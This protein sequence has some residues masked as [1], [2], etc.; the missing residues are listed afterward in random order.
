MDA[1]LDFSRF[2]VMTFDCYGTLIDWE[3]GLLRG[4][5]PMLG[6]AADEID[7]DDLLAAYAQAEAEL[8]RGRWLPY[9]RV[10]AHAAR[11]VCAQL[12]VTPAE[13]E[14]AAFGASVAD[15]PA[16]P[17]SVDALRALGARYRL[18]VITNCDDDLFAASDERL[19]RPF[20]WIVTAQQARS[21]KPATRN[22]EL[23]LERIGAPRDA[24]LHVA[25]S[26]FHDHVP[27]KRLGLATCW[28]DRRHGRR[29]S[30]ATP[31]STP[32]RPALVARD[33]AAFARLALG[34]A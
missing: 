1:E 9:R 29:G 8:E 21:Y 10:L 14:L 15:W 12:G 19:G 20:E 30:G 28:I 23:A 18:G 17:D 26:L 13:D 33:M 22:F 5:R 2:E 4:L 27:A 11:S 16:F 32:V 34:L 25:Q 31:A 3:S 7:D 6:R 24:L